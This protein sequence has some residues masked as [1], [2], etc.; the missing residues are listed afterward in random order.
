MFQHYG[1]HN[2]AIETSLKLARQFTFSN[3]AKRP[4]GQTGDQQ[5]VRSGK[6]G[7][8]RELFSD[9]H[10][11]AVKSGLG[12]LLIRWGYEKDQDW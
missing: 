9:S 10:I 3:M 11:E 4:V 1:F 12:E 8:W 5:H 7:Q 2:A 6:P